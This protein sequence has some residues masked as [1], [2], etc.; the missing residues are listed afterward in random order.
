MKG[1]SFKFLSLLLVAVLVLSS[2]AFAGTIANA[3]SAAGDVVYFDNSV[4][5][6]STVYCYMWSDGTGNNGDWPGQT[7]TNISGD[8]WAYNVTGSYDKIIFNNGSS[9]GKT[10]SDDLTYEGNGKVATP[11]SNSEKFQVTWSDY[12]GEVTLPTSATQETQATTA[13]DTTPAGGVGS[14]FLQNDAGWSTPHCYMW[15]SES[16]KN[17]AWPGVKMTDLGDGVFEYVVPKSYKGI[18]F[19]NGGSSQTGNLDF[20]GANNIYNNSTNQWEPYST[21][22]VKISSFTTDVKSPSYTTCGIK[23]TAAAT[24]SE[25]DVTYKF[26]V[27][28]TVLSD[29]AASSVVWVP[30]S[31]GDYTITVDVT[32][33]AGNE[34]SRSMNFVIKDASTLESAFI[35]AFSNSLGTN[36]QIKKNS[37]VTFTND[38]I[39][40]AVGTNLLFYKFVV[41]DPD[42][43]NNIPYY[44]LDNKYTF[45]PS[46]LGVYTIKAYV[47][48]S[49]NDTTYNT[50]QYNCVDV[51]DEN[52][53]T[54]LPSVTTPS[55]TTPTVTLQPTTATTAPTT[56]SV[57]TQPSTVANPELGDVNKDGSI[58]IIDAT[59]IQKHIA[60]LITIDTT[61]AD[62]DKDGNI[63]IKDATMIQKYICGLVTKF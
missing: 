49:M 54:T 28:G 59:F 17:A 39:G 6:W 33:T 47:Q 40:G 53:D 52:P 38:A 27:N 9:D 26:S 19:N 20:P 60:Q 10:K 7:M 31:A 29:G 11:V 30:T 24:S 34:N 50:Y 16:D 61:Y 8:I 35:R 12:T 14:V 42:G 44:K 22:P 63:T 36:I 41:T 1:K 46:K 18:I 62:T 21:G 58:N 5:N 45:T 51:I 15:N 48:N 23:I 13:Q 57:T 2:I 43:V 25:G 4:T 56:A 37:S 55:V 3:A 32:D